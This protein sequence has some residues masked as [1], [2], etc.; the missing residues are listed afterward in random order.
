MAFAVEQLSAE[1]TM[2]SVF[3][4]VHGQVQTMVEK[5]DGLREAKYGRPTHNRWVPGFDLFIDRT[6]G[7]TYNGGQP[8]TRIIG[9]AEPKQ[10][11]VLS[12]T[13]VHR[14]NAAEGILPTRV[15]S[16]RSHERRPDYS[17][18]EQG[19]KGKIAILLG[20]AGISGS[21]TSDE[22][23][24]AHSAD[25][26]QK[27]ADLDEEATERLLVVRHNILSSLHDVERVL[28][29]ASVAEVFEG[30]MLPQGGRVLPHA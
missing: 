5:L 27:V 6:E 19:Y 24:G 18:A 23:F 2:R 13:H 29:G 9:A 14:V 7:R 17:I 10:F 26:E 25:P 15:Q 21:A 30:R 8:I 1:A 11:G 4:D 12:L 20:E 16:Y 3:E 28:D 22:P